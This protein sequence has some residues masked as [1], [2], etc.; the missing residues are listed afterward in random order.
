MGP[1]GQQRVPGDVQVRARYEEV[2][3][4][5]VGR[6]RGVGARVGQHRA[7]ALVGD[8]D[9]AGPGG[10]LR[11][12]H[13]PRVDA[14]AHQLHVPVPAGDVRAAPSDEGH[15][16]TVGA[17]P[18]GDVGAGAATMRG[19]LSGRVAAARERQRRVGDGVRHQV[20]ND[21]DAGHN[22]HHLIINRRPAGRCLKL[23]RQ[24]PVRTQGTYFIAG[25]YSHRMVWAI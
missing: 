10:P 6:Q 2:V 24:P 4:Q 5:V 15:V 11:V 13:Q 25:S 12:H 19:H 8:H 20:A 17:E 14:V 21:N 3:R 9:H 16:G 23:S 1:L 18:G 22:R 7:L